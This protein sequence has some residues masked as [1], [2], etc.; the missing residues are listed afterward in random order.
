[1]T[2]FGPDREHPRNLKVQ[3]RGYFRLELFVAK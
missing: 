2:T 1:M 3:V